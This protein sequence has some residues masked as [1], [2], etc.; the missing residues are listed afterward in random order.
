MSDHPVIG[1]LSA[2][3]GSK[4]VLTGIDAAPFAA[5]ATGRF[6]G[7]PLAVVLPNGVEEVVEVV[8]LC[9]AEG[10]ALIPQGGN[11]GLVGAT[12]A[13][14]DAVI[15]NL[16]R[17][18]SIG[19]IDPT[20]R[21]ASA[22]AGVTLGRLR[23]A[24]AAE[25]LF[26]PVDHAA[27]D[28]AT[29]G[30]SI[31]TNAG[32]SLA[33]RYGRTRDQVLDITAVAGTG[34]IIHAS[35]EGSR[36]AAATLAGSEGTL[37]VVLDATLRLHPQPTDYATALV[38]LTEM[39]YAL[40]IMAHLHASCPSLYAVEFFFEEALQV[41]LE[42]TGQA[43]PLPDARPLY[44]LI[45]VAATQPCMEELERALTD[46]TT[47]GVAVAQTG[48]QR[49]ALWSYRERLNEAVSAAGM[50]VK[51]DVS[52][53]LEKLISFLD[54][55]PALVDASGPGARTVVFGH[56]A[57]GNLHVNV[58]HAP[59]PDRIEEAVYSA[60]IASGGD[61]AAEH[62]LGRAKTHW[63][64]SLGRSIDGRRALKDELDPRGILNPG[65][66]FD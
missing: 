43:R 55:L 15:V 47:E 57:N 27:R 12:A 63:M 37:A 39:S 4:H 42:H 18:D 51:M 44:L 13:P 7:S 38:G 53:P 21:S 28:S 61:I 6:P 65:V 59:D 60:V 52:V 58:L 20:R 46:V 33:W 25:E 23:D 19:P 11:T 30:G 41:A 62:G 49:A 48:T 22:G 32:G 10:I 8:R 54:E 2:A 5:D 16:T 35:R 3:V 26:F 56:L 64:R 14:Q 31:A 29:V 36:I 9:S 24:A 1:R 34:E 45:E 17:L 50:P 66:L 40:E